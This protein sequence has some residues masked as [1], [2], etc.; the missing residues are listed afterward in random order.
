MAKFHGRNDKTGRIMNHPKPSAILLLEKGKLYDEQR[1]RAAA[2][3]KAIVE[4]K[5]RCPKRFSKEERREWKYFASILKNYGLFSIA[6]APMLDL[7][8][9]NMVQYKECCRIVAE[10]GIIVKGPQ[11]GFMQ[12]PYWQAAN[13]LE[14][15]I[16][17]ILGQIG[18]S[19][20]S[21]AGLG[22]LIVK[23]QK[24]KEEF[25]ED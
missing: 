23:K 21:L 12:N 4:I 15:K 1:A 11:G 5:P 25:F 7:L 17:R 18:L 13:K 9:T 2:E 24:E 16:M 6:N 19:S 22:S 3:P 20:T 8:A 14:D 10:K